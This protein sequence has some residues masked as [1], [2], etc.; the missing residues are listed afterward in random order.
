[1]PEL[2]LVEELAEEPAAPSVVMQD[3]VHVMTR[4][5]VERFEAT[6]ARGGVVITH[7]CGEQVAQIVTGSDMCAVMRAIARH[8]CEHT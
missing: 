7:D 2:E 4:S 6:S 5:M 3:H 1:M 8:V